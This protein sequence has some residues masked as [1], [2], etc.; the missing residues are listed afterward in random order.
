MNGKET[1][2]TVATASFGTV[3]VHLCSGEVR[4]IEHVDGISLTE[5]KLIFTR[6]DHDPVILK[7]SEAYYSS[8][9][10]GSQPAAN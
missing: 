9:Q 4:E 1:V 5:S 2:G 7:R 8:F 3:Y 10:P 6:G